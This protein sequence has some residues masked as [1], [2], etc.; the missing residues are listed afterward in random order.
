MIAYSAMRRAL[1]TRLLTLSVADTGSTTLGVNSASGYT[2]ASGSFLDDGFALGMEVVA[3]GFTGENAGRGVVTGVEA[4]TL[5]VRAYDLA[6]VD[7]QYTATDRTL[8]TEGA[9][10]GRSIVAGLPL[11]RVWEGRKAQLALGVPFVEEQLLGGPTFRPGQTPN[12]HVEATPFY[13]IRFNVDENTGADALDLYA[14]AFEALFAAGQAVTLGNGDTVR[15]RG[16]TGPF[17]GQILPTGDGF[18]S[19]LATVPLRLLT[20]SPTT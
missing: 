13:T 15:V 9:S 3:S 4:L 7:G 1:R 14:D 19:L 5:T 10:S 6:E 16:D 2:R 18:A 12:G 20:L 17:R 8:T 11:A